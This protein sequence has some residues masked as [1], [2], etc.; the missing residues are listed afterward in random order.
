MLAGLVLAA[1]GGVLVAHRSATESETHPFDDWTEEEAHEALAQESIR[2]VI[3]EERLNDVNRRMASRID[4]TRQLLDGAVDVASAFESYHE[5]N[6]AGH[7]PLHPEDGWKSEF[8]RLS[9][10]AR[11]VEMNLEFVQSEE[12]LHRKDDRRNALL[13]RIQWMLADLD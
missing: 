10:I 2:T 9:W 5:L 4:A 3:L 13:I 11:Q 7:D 1:G 6:Q 8:D 12:G